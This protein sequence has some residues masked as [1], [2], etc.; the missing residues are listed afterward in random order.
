LAVWAES[1]ADF[2]GFGGL[3]G[4]ASGVPGCNGFAKVKKP[5]RCVFGVFVADP[6]E[7]NAPEPKT[8]R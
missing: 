7:A 5:S 4:V 2:A 3:V 6:K 1:T 8:K